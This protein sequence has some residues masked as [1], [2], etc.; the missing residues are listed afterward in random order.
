[1]AVLQAPSSASWA[2]Y[3]E[4]NKA[5]KNWSE[6]HFD[7]QG[8]SKTSV[9]KPNDTVTAINNVFIR[10]AAPVWDDATRDLKVGT[11]SGS[12]KPGDRVLFLEVL[13]SNS[14]NDENAYY[15]IRLL[16]LPRG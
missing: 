16:R 6:R 13:D 8:G 15:F 10:N 5:S 11:I 3:G 4:Q 14:P 12:I 7:M 1:M 9:P 2:V